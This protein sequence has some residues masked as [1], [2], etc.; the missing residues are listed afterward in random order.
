[1]F[2]QLWT[3]L[4]AGCTSGPDARAHAEAE[5]AKRLIAVELRVGSS[6]SEIEK[7]FNRHGWPFDYD[8]SERRF[9][10]DVYRAPERTHTVMVYIYVDKKREFVRSDVQV[11]ITFL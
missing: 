4:G 8:E 2:C 11:D 9:R 1:M 3:V 7:F 6:G 10:S 5:K